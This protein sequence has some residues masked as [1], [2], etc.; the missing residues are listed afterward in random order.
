MKRNKFTLIELLVVIAIIAILAAMLLPALS[1]AREKAESIT[2]T[3]NLKQIALGLNLYTADFKMLTFAAYETDSTTREKINVLTNDNAN[4]REHKWYCYLY[5]YIGDGRT[6]LCPVTDAVHTKIAYGISYSGANY[7]M[8]YLSHQDAAKKRAKLA[9][10]K[11]P[12]KTFYASCNNTAYKNVAYV[13]S[14]QVFTGDTSSS[15]WP[16][17]GKQL[18]GEVADHHSGGS[19]AF[20]LDGHCEQH[21]L[22]YY[23]NPDKTANSEPARFWA[24]YD[25]GK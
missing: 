25:A 12:S 2:C 24:Y 19:I 22:D 11:T 21:T 14:P 4:Y 1:K 17:S 20:Y 5:P 18:E 6:F 13:Y 23:R 16:G 8:P 10:H 9:A 15:Y 7:G 3:N